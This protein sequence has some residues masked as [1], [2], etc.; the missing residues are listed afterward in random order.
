MDPQDRV[1]SLEFARRDPRDHGPATLPRRRM[2]LLL[3]A[4]VLATGSGLGM[5]LEA[6]A[7]VAPVAVTLRVNPATMPPGVPVEVPF[8]M[9]NDGGATVHASMWLLKN[10]DGTL[11]A[12][13]PRCPHA[14]CL[15]K[16]VAADNEFK[17]NCHGGAFA[18]DGS[19]LAGP[20]PKPLNRLPITASGGV[21]TVE[22][23]GDFV[24]PRESLG[25]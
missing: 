1:P 21:V 9:T 22:V 15:Y 13:D 25:A 24:A 20:P 18:L 11:I 5:L 14:G 4:G 7:A 6:C 17:C 8:S 10:S 2:L 19:V 12:Y 3:G 16:W 23:P